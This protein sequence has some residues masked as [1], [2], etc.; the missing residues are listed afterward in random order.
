MVKLK[1]KCDICDCPSEHLRKLPIVT[2]RQVHLKI[3]L[4]C[5]AIMATL[6]DNITNLAIRIRVD[7]AIKQTNTREEEYL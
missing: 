2:K 4:P 6:A 5:A 1:G 3:C 7:E